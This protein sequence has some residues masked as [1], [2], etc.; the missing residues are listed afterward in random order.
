[1]DIPSLKPGAI[2]LILG[3]ITISPDRYAIP[4]CSFDRAI[5]ANWLKNRPGVA[6][7][8]RFRSLPLGINLSQTATD[9]MCP[10]TTAIRS[11][12]YASQPTQAFE[13]APAV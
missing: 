7:N 5:A 6:R 4:I 13:N 8:D 11:S 12:T 3:S 2:A 1:M 9:L 10:L